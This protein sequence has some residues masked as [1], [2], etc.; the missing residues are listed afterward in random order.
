MVRRPDGHPVWPTCIVQRIPWTA[1]GSDPSVLL[2]QLT[3]RALWMIAA[4]T[5]SG[6]VSGNQWP[7]GNASKV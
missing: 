7:A 6:R 5:W 4:A 1:A 2:T 3:D